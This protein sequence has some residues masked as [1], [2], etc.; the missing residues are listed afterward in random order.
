MRFIPLLRQDSC[1]GRRTRTAI[2]AL[3]TAT[4]CPSEPRWGSMSALG[5]LQSYG[6]VLPTSALPLNTRHDFP[7]QH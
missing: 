4:P 5:Q 6:N 1:Q 2:A 3:V 7:N